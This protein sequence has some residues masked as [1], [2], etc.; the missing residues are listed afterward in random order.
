MS[1]PHPSP[2]QPPECSP[3]G[4]MGMHTAQRLALDLHED[5]GAVRHRHRPLGEPQ[6]VCHCSDG[7]HVLLSSR[8]RIALAALRALCPRGRRGSVHAFIIENQQETT[9]GG[10]PSLAA[11]AAPPARRSPPERPIP[12]RSAAQRDFGWCWTGVSGW[13]RVAPQEC[14][15]VKVSGRAVWKAGGRLPDEA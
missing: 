3:R 10:H 9:V 5:D 13:G 11:L 2:D 6:S 8:R 12:R 14:P 1:R 15:G 4:S 7:R